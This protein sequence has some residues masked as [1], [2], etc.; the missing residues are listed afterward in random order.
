MLICSVN[1]L[2]YD[3]LYSEPLPNILQLMIKPF[4][5]ALVQ[6][7]HETGHF[8][9]LLQIQYFINKPMHCLLTPV[10]VQ[11]KQPAVF[12]LHWSLSNLHKSQQLTTC[13]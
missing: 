9:K 11:Q 1:T 7:F 5:S 13:R 12:I 10:P 4:S 8:Q 3:T 2:I 6:Q